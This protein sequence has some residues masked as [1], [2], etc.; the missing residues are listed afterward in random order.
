MPTPLPT[1]L[2]I[3]RSD[4]DSATNYIVDQGGELGDRKPRDPEVGQLP[5]YVCIFRSI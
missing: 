4:A 5:R 2:W 1:T 3:K